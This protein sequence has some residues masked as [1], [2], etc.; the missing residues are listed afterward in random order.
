MDASAAATLPS[1]VDFIVSALLLMLPTNFASYDR[2]SDKEKARAGTSSDVDAS[3]VDACC[4]ALLLC[5]ARGA[6]ALLGTGPAIAW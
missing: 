3:S 4:A 1:I 6:G 2:L 5:V